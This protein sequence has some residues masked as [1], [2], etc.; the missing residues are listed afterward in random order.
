[1]MGWSPRCYIP[2]V[3]EIG[4]MVLE[5]KIFEDGH[6]S[7]LGHVT[8]IMSINFNFIVPKS[9]HIKFG[10]KWS[11]GSEKSLLYVNDLGQRSRN[12]AKVKN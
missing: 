1:M 4:P 9:L 10:S 12:W 6:G 2:S 7:H 8:S 3:V 11:T 5:K